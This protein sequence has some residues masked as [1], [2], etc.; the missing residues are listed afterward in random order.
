MQQENVRALAATILKRLL[1]GSGSLSFHLARHKEHKD[2][3]LLQ[4][5][6]FGSC[7]SYYALEFLVDELLD[8]PLKK[9]D[10]D[11]K[12]LLIVGIYQ[13]KELSIPDHAVLNE[14]VSATQELNKTWAKALVNAILRNYLRQKESLG[15]SIETA[16]DNIQHSFPDWLLQRLN[17]VWPGQL[18]DILAG[19]NQ[20]PPMTL[21]VNQDKTSRADLI[22]SLAENHIKA[23][24]GELA[25]TAIY[26]DKPK[27]VTEIPG[28]QQGLLS[29]QDEASQLAVELLRLQS[30]HRV[31]DACADP[32]G[33]TCHML[34]SACSL[35]RLVA[36]DLVPDRVERIR[37]NLSRLSLQAVLHCADILDRDS[38]WDRELFDRILVDAPCSATG[39]IRR[40]PD[41]KLLRSKQE[42]QKL[43]LL[44]GQILETLW[45]CLEKNG[46]LLYATCSLLPE[47]NDQQIER[48]L[49]STDSAKYEGIAADWGVECRYGRQLLTGACEGPDGFFYSLLRK[50]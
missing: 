32:G 48:F 24:A 38:W 29:V 18:K 47:E 28:F 22:E 12:C 11:I 17:S 39:V 14:T 45:P 20:R 4:E 46:L 23:N 37:E 6:C 31:L 30:G 7:R 19:S 44:Q 27:T 41:I 43:V 2:Y 5:I 35:T 8:K 21:R 1:D 33:K 10:G 3:S 9:K 36:V 16:P 42:I 13:L 40:H 49:Q 26:L 15:K 25:K 34:E 50:S